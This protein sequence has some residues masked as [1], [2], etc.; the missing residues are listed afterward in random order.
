M[1]HVVKFTFNPFQENTYLLYDDTKECIIIDPGCYEMHER[2]E[3]LN[4]I[5]REELKPVRLL[6]THCHI[7]HVVGNKFVADTY[8]LGLEIHE[9]EVSVLDSLETVAAMY[10]IANV[11]KSPAPA[12]FIEAGEEIAFGETVLKTLFTPGHSPASISFYCK[13]DAFVIAG[14][15]LFQQSVGRV[16]L[17]GGDGPTLI[18]SIK[19]QLFPLGDDVKVYPGHGRA[20]TIGEEKVGNPFLNG[21]IIL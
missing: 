15:V 20:T 21:E 8:N 6:N 16:D 14:D 12:R 1:T 2:Q 10:G 4:F 7:D 3:L 19:E 17:P 13:K 11:E 9:G 5:Q 18:K